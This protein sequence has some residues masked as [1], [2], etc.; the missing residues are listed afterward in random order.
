[1]PLTQDKTELSIDKY[2]NLQ[3]KDIEDLLQQQK[4]VQNEKKS[5]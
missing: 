5:K 2:E 4:N 1:M 3:L